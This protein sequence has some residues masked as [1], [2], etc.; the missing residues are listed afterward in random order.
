M[1]VG[2][3]GHGGLLR[4]FP[5]ARPIRG[6]TPRHA[7]TAGD[8]SFAV[9]F[10]AETLWHFDGLPDTA[11]VQIGSFR[12]RVQLAVQ[13]RPA[14]CHKCGERG[15]IRRECVFSLYCRTHDHETNQCRNEPNRNA[16]AGKAASVVSGDEAPTVQG[17]TSSTPI[18][19]VPV[20]M[21]SSTSMSQ[22]HAGESAVTSAPTSVP[23]STSISQGRALESAVTSALTSVIPSVPSS[24][25][26]SKGRT[27][28]S[29]VTSAV[30]SVSPFVQSSSVSVR[31][32][33]PPV[34]PPTSGAQGVPQSSL[35]VPVP[36]PKGKEVVSRGGRVTK[37]KSTKSGSLAMAG[38]RG[39]EK[40][41]APGKKLGVKRTNVN[42]IVGLKKGKL[43]QESQLLRAEQVRM[44][45]DS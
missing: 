36:A 44:E 33:V 11:W 16:V 12:H 1:R 18:V 17:G 31:P 27:R 24:T 21:S 26:M 9:Q 34:G 13:G 40:R 10:N 28:E 35:P 32:K 42:Q 2:V 39:A 23:S 20:S 37:P 38:L 15:H 4:A 8:L 3:I 41:V 7:Q 25:S 14:R 22:W 6:S 29:A 45:L 5:F 19:S 43:Q 30:T